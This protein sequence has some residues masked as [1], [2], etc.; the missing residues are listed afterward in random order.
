ML[1]RR[2]SLGSLGR[3]FGYMVSQEG[4]LALPQKL[5]EIEASKA[6]RWTSA[7]CSRSC[8]FPPGGGT[9]YLSCSVLMQDPISELDEPKRFDLPEGL[10]EDVFPTSENIKT[11]AGSATF[12]VSLA[13]G[14]HG[15]GCN[16]L[17]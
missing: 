10:F 11:Q 13:M 6:T 2:K 15:S 1:S 7:S 14:L 4:F 17:T 5:R 3:R 9:T 8:V 16:D 12:E